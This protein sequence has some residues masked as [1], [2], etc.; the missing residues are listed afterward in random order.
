MIPEGNLQSNVDRFN[1][2]ADNYDQHRPEASSLVVE[3]I[4][5]YLD[6]NVALVADIGCGTG[7]ST[8]I[9]KDTARR[10]VGIEPNPDM[11]GIAQR[12]LERAGTTMTGT[13]SF[14]SGFSNNLPFEDGTVDVI[15]CSQSFHWM[16]PESTLQEAGRV[17][18]QG[19]VFAAF[20]C[21]WPP[22]LQWQIEQAYTELITKADTVLE[23]EAPVEQQAHKWSKDQHLANLHHSGQ[24]RYI[25]EIVFHNR[26]QC[27][28][29]RY[30]GLALS[31]GGI[32]SL[33]KL[34]N[35]TLDD[36]IARF[37]KLVENH[38]EGRTL[39]ILFSYRMRIGIK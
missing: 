4:S 1:G 16:D 34:G 17:L 25:R 27:D 12:K 30:T 36:D 14:E 11:R 20:D 29:A 37:V 8:F 23:Q 38:F 6:R 21:D 19:G 7:L 13:I 3:I 35:R 18:A 32:Q 39:D 5:R 10:I 24:F 22:V 2:F 31:Q 33:F 28:A 9:W 15:T 26:E